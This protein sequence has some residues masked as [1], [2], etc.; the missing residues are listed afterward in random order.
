[1]DVVAGMLVISEA[2]CFL[3]SCLIGCQLHLT[4][5]ILCT[6]GE[7]RSRMLSK[8][9]LRR[10]HSRLPQQDEHVRSSEGPQPAGE[11]GDGTDE[12]LTSILC[13]ILCAHAHVQEQQASVAT[14]TVGDAVYSCMLTCFEKQQQ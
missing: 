9:Q 1:M 10:I 5:L 11:E 12:S 13:Q 4:I 14:M 3:I 8:C 6:Q 2:A 7:P